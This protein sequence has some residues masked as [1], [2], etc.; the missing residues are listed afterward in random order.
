MRAL[1]EELDTTATIHLNRVWGEVAA[2]Q[3]HRGMLPTEYLARLD[4]RNPHPVCAPRRC[5][6]ECEERMLGEARVLVALNA[7]IAA[8]RGL[9][10]RVAVLEDEGCTIGM[11]SDDMAKDMVEVTHPGLFMER[12]RRCDGRNPTPAQPLRWATRNGCAAMGIPDAGFPAPGN[13]ADPMIVRIDQ[14]HLT[15]MIRAASTFVHRG[16]PHDVEGVMVAG[17]WLVRAGVVR[18]IDE[19]AI[20]READRIARS[21]WGCLFAAKPEL[22]IL[23]G[24][25]AAF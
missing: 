8:R 2:A 12:V 4:F 25:P 14:P 10:P 11:A 18:T 24:L 23:A 15:P 9:S 13:K 3:A 6:A 20:V 19:A 16:Q 22:R 1:Q 21:A 7:A 17:V 5:L